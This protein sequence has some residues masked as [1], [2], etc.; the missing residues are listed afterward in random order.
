MGAD[1]INVLCWTF[2]RKRA[3]SSLRNFYLLAVLVVLLEV[4]LS[5]SMLVFSPYYPLTM[6][7]FCGMCGI[8]TPEVF[9]A[10]A[11]PSFSLSCIRDN[12][13]M[14][15]ETAVFSWVNAFLASLLGHI[16]MNFGFLFSGPTE[17]DL[18]HERSKVIHGWTIV[19]FA[20][21]IVDCGIQIWL[22]TA[23]SQILEDF[24]KP[25]D[26]TSTMIFDS[27]LFGDTTYTSCAND[28][29][30]QLTTLREALN[31]YSQFIL[32]LRCITDFMVIM[33]LYKRVTHHIE[34]EVDLE[35]ERQRDLEEEI[36]SVETEKK[37][38]DKIVVAGSP[39][40]KAKK[41][42]ATAATAAASPVLEVGK[43]EKRKGFDLI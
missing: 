26:D 18:V 5:L 23:S 39:S 42:P 1:S 33:S 11:N 15:L 34:M 14:A 16:L 29:I 8:S 24:D 10:M 22:S 38:D 21:L 27:T 2:H 28:Q 9:S 7:Y 4:C 32:T 19:A 35:E 17:H 41:P 6:S 20:I 3:Y 31:N 36:D 37:K 12:I 30:M 13:Y 43:G 40:H 25:D